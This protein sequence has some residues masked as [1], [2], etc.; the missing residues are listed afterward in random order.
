MYTSLAISTLNV[1]AYTASD[2]QRVNQELLNLAQRLVS[3]M[4]ARANLD[5]VRFYQ[6]QVHA[7]EAK[8]ASA[9]EALAHYRNQSKVFS[10]A[11]QANLQAQLVSKLKEQQLTA[12]IQ[13]GQMKI[14]APKNP[15]IPLI[16][17]SIAD[18]QQQIA[19]QSAMV[20][21]NR[22]SLASK[23]AEYERLNL[24]QSFAQREL[25]AAINSLEQS[26]IQAEKRQ[27]FIETVVSPNTPDEPLHPKRARG[28]IATF[29]IGLF[30]WGILSVIFAGI[31]EHHER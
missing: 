26:R 9:T 11:P 28:I 8:A 6:Q 29:A 17:K 2:A 3:K 23:S 22:R 15:R 27:L 14:N 4:N 10:P 7:A 21:G 18:L 24:A 30:V 31:R 5:S 1:N 25:A 13:L 16:E 20:A 19:T 12:Q